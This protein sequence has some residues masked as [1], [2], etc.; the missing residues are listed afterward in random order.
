MNTVSWLEPSYLLRGSAR[1]QAAYHALTAA[2]I[3]DVL[4]EYLP[5]LVGTI[6]IDI[7]LPESDLDVVCEVHDFD[8]FQA[9][10]EQA[11]RHHEGFRLREHDVHGVPALVVNFNHDGFMIELFAQPVPVVQQH[12]FI[13]MVIEARLLALA[14]KA[15]RDALRD[16]KRGGLKTEPAFARYFG[17]DGNPYAALLALAA[18]DDDA[19]RAAVGL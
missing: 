17:L 15:A 9:I 6:P 1:Q 5:V 4:D 13:H 7:D 16:L 19:L 8:T 2:G 10:V 3:F 18:L 12:A 14:G 11:F